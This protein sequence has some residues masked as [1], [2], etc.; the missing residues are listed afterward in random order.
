MM[1]EENLKHDAAWYD[2][3]KYAIQHYLSFVQP[4]QWEERTC[5]FK[6]ITRDKQSC[7]ECLS[8]KACPV[9]CKMQWDYRDNDN[10]KLDGYRED[11][12]NHD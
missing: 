11:R 5:I 7:E 4:K 8:V 9:T 10:N 3:F 1:G 2:D 6:W 12:A